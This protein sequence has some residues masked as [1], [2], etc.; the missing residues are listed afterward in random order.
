MT[1]ADFGDTGNAMADDLNDTQ[2][3]TVPA[4]YAPLP[5]HR[6]FGRMVGPLYEGTA[7]DGA[8]RRA[9]RVEEHHANGMGNAH[10]GMLMTFADVAWGH[11]VS[12]G[13]DQWW[14]TVRLTCDFLSS[15]A[16]GEWVEGT[17]TIIGQAGSLYTVRGRVWTGERTLLTGTGTFKVIPR[18]D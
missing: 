6:G 10:G 16:L 5:W 7:P 8:Y 2:T 1:E 9:F 15:P 11:A 4:G 13:H 12:S 18:R 17:G 3:S 14:V